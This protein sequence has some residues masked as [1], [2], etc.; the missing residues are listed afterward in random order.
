MRTEATVVQPK[1]RH[2]KQVNGPREERGTATDS[3][4]AST[5]FGMYWSGLVGKSNRI[6][7]SVEQIQRLNG[8]TPATGER[9]DEANMS[10]ID[11]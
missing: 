2:P 4:A 3:T 11:R 6:E 1:T 7:L 10:A 9:H 8:L 5:A